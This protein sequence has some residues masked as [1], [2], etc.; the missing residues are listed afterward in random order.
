MN[1]IT[2]LFMENEFPLEGE[3]VEV[4]EPAAPPPRLGAM[5]GLEADILALVS[6]KTTLNAQLSEEIIKLKTA[7]PRD[8]EFGQFAKQAVPFLDALDRIVEM[9]KTQQQDEKLA[10]WHKSVEAAYQRILKLFEKHNMA[11]V[12]CL[13]QEVDL[14][15]QEVVE[16]RQTASAPHNTVIEERQKGIVFRGKVLRDARVVVACNEDE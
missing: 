8:D 1:L 14:D 12:S 10:A 4:F 5:A 7:A 3:P 11:Q 9:G 13:G 16:Y 15:R 2:K 6:G